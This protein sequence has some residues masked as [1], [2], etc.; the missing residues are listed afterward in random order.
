MTEH[1]NSRLTAFMNTGVA[2]KIIEYLGC[3]V[4]EI[5]TPSL[6]NLGNVCYGNEAHIQTLINLGLLHHLEVILNHKKK[7]IKREVCWT[8]SNIAASVPKH[9]ETL[10]SQETLMNKLYQMLI[11]EIEPK[12]V[13]LEIG[14]IFSNAANAGNPKTLINIY[15]TL[16]LMKIYLS[17]V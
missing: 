1:S 4:P 17:F 7:V 14:W 9:V 11:S 2:P 8:L 6:R 3:G 10:F 13:R 5:L 16:K 15:H 12:E